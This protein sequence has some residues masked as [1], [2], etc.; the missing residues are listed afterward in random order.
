MVNPLYVLNFLKNEANISK[1]IT[2]F[3]KKIQNFNNLSKM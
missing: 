1:S 3:R 2:Y